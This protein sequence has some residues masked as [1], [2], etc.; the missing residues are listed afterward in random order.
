[1]GVAVDAEMAA[2]NGGGDEE[3]QEGDPRIRLGIVC[4]GQLVKTEGTVNLCPP[5]DIET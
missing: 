4:T 3:P 5:E 2:R 1:M